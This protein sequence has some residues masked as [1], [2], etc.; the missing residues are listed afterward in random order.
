[1]LY[2]ASG[3]DVRR[4]AKPLFQIQGPTT[5]AQATTSFCCPKLL[6]INLAGTFKT[7]GMTVSLGKRFFSKNLKIDP[8]A[9]SRVPYK[10]CC[11]PR[12]DRREAYSASSSSEDVVKIRLRTLARALCSVSAS[13]R[14]SSEL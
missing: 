1:M 11:H 10:T 6:R 12:H 2:R 13:S 3:L 4:N 9:F 7:E 8:D 14:L 5:A